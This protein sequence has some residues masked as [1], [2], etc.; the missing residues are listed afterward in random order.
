ML[1]PGGKI[2]NCFT[3]RTSRFD[4]PANL[5][6]IYRV[7]Q[8]FLNIGTTAIDSPFAI[9]ARREIR[10]P[11]WIANDSLPDLLDVEDAFWEEV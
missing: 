9:V 8:E 5:L 4:P 3:L 10:Q 1:A 7:L 2:R 6:L 11:N